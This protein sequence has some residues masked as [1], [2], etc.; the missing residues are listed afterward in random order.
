MTIPHNPELGGAPSDDVW[1]PQRV[2]RSSRGSTVAFV[3]PATRS[4]ST[5]QAGLWAGDLASTPTRLVSEVPDSNLALREGSSSEDVSV[6][7]AVTT[8]GHSEC[9]VHNLGTGEQKRFGLEG[10]AETVEWSLDGQVLVL[11][12][13]P[14]AD[15]A[16]LTSGTPLLGDAPLAR[17]NREPIGFRRVWRVNPDDG[18][19]AP[20]TPANISVWEFK[21]LDATRIVAIASSNPTEAGWYASTLSVLGPSPEERR[22]V[23]TATWQLTSP[24]VS[25]DGTRVAFVE[26]WTVE[27]IEPEV[28]ESPRAPG[29]V[30]AWRATISRMPW[31]YD[32]RGRFSDASSG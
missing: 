2:T 30:L 9:V 11:V 23:Y 4:G 28:L 17:S 7:Y 21:P 31:E 29:S 26:G 12:A 22:D 5:E 14:G 24:S 18:G 25:P 3:V 20:M 32:S 27:A 6:L 8:N 1:H 10:V 13:E 19:T 15:S 16:S